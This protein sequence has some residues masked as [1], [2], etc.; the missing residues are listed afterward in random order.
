VRDPGNL[1]IT[2][3]L[4]IPERVNADEFVTS[5]FIKYT[6]K[7]RRVTWTGQLNIDNIFNNVTNQ[8][9]ISRYPRYTDPR[10]ITVTN[11]FRF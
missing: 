5:P 3:Q 2:G 4:V 7:F 9:R 11:F 1:F 8:G 10:Q 6:A